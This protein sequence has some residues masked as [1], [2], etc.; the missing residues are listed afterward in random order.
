MKPLTDFNK[1]PTLAVYDIEATDWV[2]VVLV[3]HV[4]ELNNKQTFTSID[5]YL[6]W[7]YSDRFRGTHVWAHWG[8][9]YDHRFIIA[10]ATKHKWC[11]EIVQSGNLMI[12]VKLIHPKEVIPLLCVP[13]Y[14]EIRKI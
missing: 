10:F 5:S 14:A 7:L 8:G 1:W 2:N 6:D 12:I 9:H 4:D 11:W 3:G 13:C